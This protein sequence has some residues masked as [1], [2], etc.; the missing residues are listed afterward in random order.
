MIGII[1]DTHDNMPAIEAAIKFFNDKGTAMVLHAGDFI[2]PFTAKA[3]NELPCPLAGVYGNNDGERAGLSKAYSCIGAK[4]KEVA[5]IDHDKRK[6]A[7][8][9]GQIPEILSA[10]I[11]SRKYDIVVTGHTH[12]PSVTKIEETLVVNPGE[13]CGYLTGKRTVGLLDTEWMECTIHEI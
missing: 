5:E 13:C 4:I 2:S 9:H 12:I 11:S 7:V 10:L 3:F 6:I 1:S 8:Y